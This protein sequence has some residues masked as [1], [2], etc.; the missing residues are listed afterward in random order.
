M[1]ARSLTF[2]TD[3]I[4]MMH[5]VTW[6]QLTIPQLTIDWCEVLPRKKVVAAIAKNIRLRQWL[7]LHLFAL[8]SLLGYT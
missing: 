3:D 8:G 7:G 2:Q 4:R 5:L 6:Q 1:Y